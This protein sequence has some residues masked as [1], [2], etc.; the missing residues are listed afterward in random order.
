MRIGIDIRNIGKKR[1]G[2]EAVFF[3]LTKEL[4]KI[5]SQNE[6]YLLTDINDEKTLRNIERDLEIEAKDN[7]EIVSL[8]IP[9][10]IL[11]SKLFNNKFI[12]NIWTLP[13]YLKKHPVDV[14]HTQ[15]IT[16]FFV[17]RKIKI[18]THIHDVSFKV[19][20]QFM[21]WSDLFFLKILIPLSIK[22][23]DKIIAVSH[24]TRNEILKYYK[25]PPEKVEVVYN[26]VSSPFGKGRAREGFERREKKENVQIDNDSQNPLVPSFP[27]GEKLKEKYNLPEKFILYIGTF[28]PR[29]NL[30]ILI[31][32]FKKLKTALNS[33]NSIQNLK[34]VLAGKKGHNYDKKIDKIIEKNDLKEAVIFPG[35]IDEKDKFLLMTSAQIFCFPSLYEGFG[36]PVLEA[37]SAGA[38]SVISQI[39]PHQEI[40]EGAVEFFNP[41][42]AQDLAEKLQKVLKDEN[43]RNYLISKGKGISY[44][45]S[46][47]KSAKKL[48][49]IFKTL[50]LK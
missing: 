5:D 20:T 22:R 32:A 31:E 42:S 11:P 49:S 48:L 45:F 7:F 2:D 10:L 8:K 17:S 26:A 3:N 25:V 29:K 6:Y 40:A 24:F 36:L 44:Q 27:K 50:D 39:P 21:K 35:Y 19:Y 34:L 15:Y 38:P 12:W 23:T 1:T 28:Q 37:L 18:V 43:R 30:P 9:S 16:P 13:M 33:T 47:Q 4:A 14:Y 46:W 41:Y